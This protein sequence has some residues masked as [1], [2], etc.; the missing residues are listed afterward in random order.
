MIR[1]NLQTVSSIMY[2]AVYVAKGNISLM[3]SSHSVTQNQ[4]GC[5]FLLCFVSPDEIMIFGVILAASCSFT[6]FTIQKMRSA[7][8][9]GEKQTK[10]NTRHPLG[11]TAASEP[12]DLQQSAA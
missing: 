3:S 12:A 10:K 5:V 6:S 4:S 1:V 2:L 8:A 11:Y 7:L 9:R